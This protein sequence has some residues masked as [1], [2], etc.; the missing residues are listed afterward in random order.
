M[1]GRRWHGVWEA[2]L[3]G[4]HQ[5]SSLFWIMNSGADPWAV[6]S[7]GDLN[8]MG[9]CVVKGGDISLSVYVK[10][11]LIYVL[12]MFLTELFRIQR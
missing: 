9:Q 12:R 2:L 7:W 3:M 10:Y 11:F 1:E 6:C 5:G 4:N 8:R